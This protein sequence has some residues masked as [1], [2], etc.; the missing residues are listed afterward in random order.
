MVTRSEQTGEILNN[1]RADLVAF[2]RELLRNPYWVLN[3]A[4][5]YGA[6]INWS[7]QYEFAFGARS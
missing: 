7:A 6:D 2:G 1:N 3:T 4:K 5:D